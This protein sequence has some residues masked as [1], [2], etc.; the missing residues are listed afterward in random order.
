MKLSTTAF[1]DGAA[2]PPEYAFCK[3]DPPVARDVVDE[4]ESRSRVGR[5]ADRH[6]VVRAALP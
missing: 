5:R 6:R 1:V 2:I 3:P 4:P